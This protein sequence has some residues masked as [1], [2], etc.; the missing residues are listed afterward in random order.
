MTQTPADATS[1]HGYAAYDAASPLRPYSFTRRAL[2]PD[3]VRI[4]IHYCG[5]CH[6]DLHVARN[7]WRNT[8]YPVVPGHEIVGEVTAVGPAVSR[9]KPG[10]RV[11]VGCLVDSCRDCRECDAGR[12]QYCQNGATLTYNGKDRPTG[13]VTYGGY[14]THIVVRDEFVLRVPAGLDPARAAPLLCAGITTYSPLRHWRVGAGSQVAVVGLGGLGH[15]GVKLAHALG[16]EVTVV[17]RSADKAAEARSLGARHVL[18]SSD[19]EAMKRAMGRFDLVLDTVPVAHAVDPYLRLTQAHGATVLVGMVDT[20]P[21]FHSRLLLGGRKTLS[22]SAIGGIAETQE[23]LDFCAARGIVAE[24]EMTPM[25]RIDEAFHRMEK[26]DVRYRFVIDM[27][28]LR[29]QG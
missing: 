19:A 11:A 10:D 14:S 13:D 9:F 16:A 5:V 18:L 15:L 2:R 12:E 20:I 6:T 3:D 22:S 8:T 21:A 17:T 23:L 7:D 24:C 4:E 28:S 1:C 25:Q 29:Q 27:Q 26:G